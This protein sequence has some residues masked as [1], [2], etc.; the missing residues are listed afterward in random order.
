MALRS[1]ISTSSG[2]GWLLIPKGV[3]T[4][5]TVHG[6]G[7]F[8]NFPR[9]GFGDLAADGFQE[10]GYRQ[11]E[12][13]Q[14]CPKTALTKPTKPPLTG[15]CQF[16]QFGLGAFPV[17]FFGAKRCK[18]TSHGSALPRDAPIPDVSDRRPPTGGGSIFHR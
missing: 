13:F 5:L 7:A 10:H 14:K 6:A 18:P 2:S 12:I 1:S 3:L 9:S 17:F 4:V 15:F 16:R 11:P 8:L